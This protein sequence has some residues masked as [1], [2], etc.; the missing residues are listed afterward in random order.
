MD[1]DQLLAVLAPCGLDCSRCVS[2]ATGTV[3]QAARALSA[4]LAGFAA[5]AP[6]F[7]AHEPAL[8]RWSHFEGVLSFL[9]RGSCAGC[10]NP[11]AACNG[12]CRVKDCVRERGVDFCCQCPDY[13]CEGH[14]LF[15]PL[16]ARWRVAQD[17]M[18]A[19]GAEAWWR[20]QSTRPRY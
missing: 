5:K 9:E 11:G 7:A 1:H 12:A 10:R 17:F 8:A 19:H 2:S 13:P 15:P 6:I 16:A 3:R 14:G 20:D 18:R 4:S